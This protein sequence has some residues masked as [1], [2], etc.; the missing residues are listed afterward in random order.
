MRSTSSEGPW[1]A[2]L[3]GGYESYH[4]EEAILSEA[5]YELRVFGGGR[6]DRAE[7]LAFAQGAAGVL[8]R[9]TELDGPAFDALPSVQ[10][11]ARYGIGYDNIDVEAATK[12]EVLVSVVLGYANHSV[13]DHALALIM[14]CLRGLRA[15]KDGLLGHYGEPPTESMLELHET[16]VGIV[17]LGRIGGTFCTKVKPL[18][19]R[20]LACDPYVDKGRFREL[21]AEAVSLDTL[22]RESDI[23]SI[24]C[25]LTDETR[26]LFDAAAFAKMRDG[27]ILVN[28][29]RGPVVD[30]DALFEALESDKLS[31]AGIDV[32][33]D[34]PPL[35]NR[36]PL[37]EH[38]RLVATGHYAWFSNRASRELQRRTAE[39]M[40]A[41]LEGRVPEGCLNGPAGVSEEGRPVG[42]S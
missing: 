9:W 4:A 17:G 11:V 16:V 10:C 30:E 32:F 40:V 3:D 5:G 2:N 23:I 21:G 35:E 38:P 22:L 12:R 26:A 29:A 41:M 19:A 28:T 18:V 13:S 15:G 33:G 36:F 39:N 7:K 31:G 34:E 1:V 37:L 6:H 42:S 8:V 14:A 27:A 24:H 25:N 20:V